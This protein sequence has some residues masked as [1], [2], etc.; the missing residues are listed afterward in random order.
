MENHG[1]A[2]FVREPPALGDRRDIAD[3]LPAAVLARRLLLVCRRVSEA[4]GLRQM[5]S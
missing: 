5:I 3:K 2:V 1:R 4:I